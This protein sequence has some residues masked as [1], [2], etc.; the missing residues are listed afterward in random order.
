M[1]RR[2][3]RA[4]VR[5]DGAKDAQQIGSGVYAIVLDLQGRKLPLP[6]YITA[7]LIYVCEMI[8][9]SVCKR[10]ETLKARHDDVS[11][12]LMAAVNEF[13]VAL[14]ESF[15]AEHFEAWTAAAVRQEARR[16]G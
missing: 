5:K 2:R 12:Y 4:A 9:A 14:V 11:R 13:V 15:D 3:V 7:P 6:V 16:S 8:A 10:D 1:A